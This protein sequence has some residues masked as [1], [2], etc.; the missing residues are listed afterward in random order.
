MSNQQQMPPIYDDSGASEE[1]NF[2]KSFF[3]DLKNKQ[4]DFLDE[5]SKTI[6]ERIATFL[7]VLFGVTVL[8]S[9]F[10][11]PYL[12]SNL[13]TKIMVIV[14]LVFYLTAL[15][16][17]LWGIQPRAYKEY[18]YNV[19]NM[20]REWKTLIRRKILWLRVA[21]ILFALGSVALGI[22]IVFIIWTA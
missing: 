7:A 20:R 11:P 16:T 1:G 17:A 15:G 6:I 21:G 2:F 8:S 13:A 5:S 10:P 12:K 9:T 18:T 14:T 22:L 3:N 19:D 4:P